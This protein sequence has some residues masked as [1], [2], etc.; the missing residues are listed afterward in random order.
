MK[1]ITESQLKDKVNSLREYLKV[2]ENQ[3]TDEGWFDDAVGGVKKFFGGGN[4]AAAPA[5]AAAAAP[6]P[7][8][9]AAGKPGETP[10]AQAQAAAGPAGAPPA[11][12]ANA[13]AQQ[14]NTALKQI[15]DLY[16][17]AKVG[18]PPQDD[19]VRQ[20]YGLPPAL[21]PLAQWDGKMPQATG[22]DFL[23]RNLFGRDASKA[24]A[25]QQAANN[26]S[27][28]ANAK[29]DAETETDVKEL[30]TLVA[31]VK[32]ML[33]GKGPAPV[34]LS[35]TQP[36]NNAS[37]GYAGATKSASAPAASVAFNQGK[38][39]GGYGQAPPAA[40]ATLAENM[41]RL[42]KK[43]RLIEAVVPNQTVDPQQ[44]AAANAPPELDTTGKDDI[45]KK[46]QDLMAKI[47][48]NNEDP[49]QDVA[50]ALS[51]AQ[52]A[53][54]QID[55]AAKNAAPPVSLAQDNG[56]NADGQNAGI[57]Q[58]DGSS[59]NPETGEKY[60][61]GINPE[62]GEKYNQSPAA[63]NRDSM[64]FGQAFADAKAKGEKQ[65]DWKGKPYAVKMAP[66]PQ[67]AAPEPSA[68]NPET[69]E[70][71]TPLPADNTAINPET[72][73]QYTALPAD[74]TGINQETGEKY[75]MAEAVSYRDD[76]ALARIVH[77][78]GR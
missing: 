18:Y 3:Q 25:G 15:Q 39:F 41:A 49:P 68:I 12:A 51:D 45:R 29:S 59:I 22:A 46:I 36:V 32:D 38:A 61:T 48:G 26:I 47:N 69:G 77:L 65:F 5:P 76:Q 52:S 6:A 72:G 9:A 10:Q 75:Q 23:T 56:V 7:A 43:I 50:Q 16:A 62:T 1:K 30:G 19:I 33:A 13:K 78:A 14:Y 44:A 20:R 8:P 34:S 17:K 53:L 55:A 63:P 64:S 66:A 2:Y 27:N 24:V 37:S 35:S 40:P 73:E 42:N 54:D 21:P 58:T 74:K 11:P 31:Q 28:T 4:T 60:S 70:K 57:A 67:T 71:Y